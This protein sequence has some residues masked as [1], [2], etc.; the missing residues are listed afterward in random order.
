MQSHAIFIMIHWSTMIWINVD[1]D[2]A[3]ELINIKLNVLKLIFTINF[4][5]E[6]YADYLFL[7][8]QAIW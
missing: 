6:V 7:H 5:T 8:T 4:I 2:F 1:S 3:T